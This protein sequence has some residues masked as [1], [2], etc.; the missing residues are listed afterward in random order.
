MKQ[1]NR[2]KFTSRFNN[3]PYKVIECKGTRITAENDG[4]FIA[5]NASFFKSIPNPT[6]AKDA[7]SDTNSDIEIDNRNKKT[8]DRIIQPWRSARTRRA[9]ERYGTAIPFSTT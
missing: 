9:P 7:Y 3:T 1:K 8:G 6:Y 5:R 4:Y 2:N